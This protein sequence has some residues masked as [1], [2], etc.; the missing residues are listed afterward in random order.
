MN[1]PQGV[2]SV[3]ATDDGRTLSQRIEIKGTS[4]RE[5]VFRCAGPAVK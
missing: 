2:F 5:W 1:S 3:E 4:R